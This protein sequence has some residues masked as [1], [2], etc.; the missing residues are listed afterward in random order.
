MGIGIPLARL[1]AWRIWVIWGRVMNIFEVKMFKS[2]P[3][4]VGQ[5]RVRKGRDV[6]WRHSISLADRPLKAHILLDAMPAKRFG[7]QLDWQLMPVNHHQ[8]SCAGSV[9]GFHNA[10]YITH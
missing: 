2:L 7:G 5:H 4:G 1:G 9:E 3:V 6:V 10:L 8:T